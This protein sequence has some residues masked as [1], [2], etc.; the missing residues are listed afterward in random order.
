MRENTQKL[1][2]LEE[3]L[4]LLEVILQLR[5]SHYQVPKVDEFCQTKGLGE[6]ISRVFVGVDVMENHFLHFYLL[7][8]LVE[9]N[10]VVAGSF[11][12]ALPR[13]RDGCGVVLLNRSGEINFEDSQLFEKIAEP[14]VFFAEGDE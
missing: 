13:Q 11:C 14:G 4:Q 12:R 5:A 6:E 7:F 3:I 1:L 2:R 8:E 10:V 9:G